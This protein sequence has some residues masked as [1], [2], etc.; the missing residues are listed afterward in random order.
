MNGKSV[1][2]TVLL[3]G[4]LLIDAEV[5]IVEGHV[6]TL[7]CNHERERAGRAFQA[8]ADGHLYDLHRALQPTGWSLWFRGGCGDSTEEMHDAVGWRGVFR[9]V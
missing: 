2:L 7:A 9:G 4:A 3:A 5:A 6:H 1:L 8:A